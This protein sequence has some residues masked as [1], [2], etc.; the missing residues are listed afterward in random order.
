MSVPKEASLS[1]RVIKQSVCDSFYGGALF[2]EGVVFL[3]LASAIQKRFARANL[4]Q[5]LLSC[6]FCYNS[7]ITKHV[8]TRRRINKT[9]VT[10]HYICTMC[11]YHQN[12]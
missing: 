4:K 10:M 6:V 7:N 11:H 3:N 5:H 1:K 9:M 8:K 12:I 2:V